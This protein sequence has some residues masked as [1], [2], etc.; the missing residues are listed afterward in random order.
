MI[1]YRVGAP[2][3]KRR[4]VFILT[5]ERP[6][7]QAFRVVHLVQDENMSCLFESHSGCVNRGLTSMDAGWWLSSESLILPRAEASSLSLT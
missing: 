4:V 5:A 1:S 6:V 7:L 3:G 2:R